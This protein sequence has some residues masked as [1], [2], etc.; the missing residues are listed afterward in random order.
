ME[1]FL[2][3]LKGKLDRIEGKLDNMS[4]EMGEIKREN[5][6]MRQ[7]NKQL[8]AELNEVNKRVEIL[9]REIRKKNLVIH[10]LQET[11]NEEPQMLQ[12]K[13]Q[14][15][16]IK[17]GVQIKEEE[18]SEVRRMGILKNN[19]AR[20]TFVQ[21]A[22]GKKRTEILKGG[23]NLKGSNVYINEDYSKEIQTQR[24]EL[25]Y[26]MKKAREQGNNA[27]INYN[28]LTI[29]GEVYTIE[30]VRNWTKNETEKEMETE[31]INKGRTI[32]QRSPSEERQREKILKIT[33]TRSRSTDKYPSTKN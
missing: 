27:K 23:H 21:L 32:S 1:E 3:H 9:E 6:E 19:K 24:R 25:I 13:V 30:Q 20:P 17:T 29:N 5:R 8:K 7:E 2:E 28:K 31:R 4:E 33:Q 15:V 10:G 26:H 18:L 22:S 14:E 12:R 11:D 16:L